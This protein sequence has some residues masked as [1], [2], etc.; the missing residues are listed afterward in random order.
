MADS[1][2][3]RRRSWRDMTQTVFGAGGGGGSQKWRSEAKPKPR[4][5][6]RKEAMTWAQK[7][8]ATAVALALIALAAVLIWWH[9]KTTPVVAV[10]VT[11]YPDPIPPNAWALEDGAALE[12]VSGSDYLRSIFEASISNG[13][14][15]A[16]EGLAALETGTDPKKWLTALRAAM[17]QGASVAGEKVVVVYLSMHGALDDQRR[18]CLIL[19]SKPQATYAELLNT[20]NWIPLRE[21]LDAAESEAKAAG[22]QIVLALDADRIDSAVEL[23]IVTNDFAKAAFGEV[24]NG[25]TQHPHVVVINSTGAGQTA[26][27]SPEMRR[28]VFSF[29]FEHGLRGAAD[30][31][32]NDD[33][34]VSVK[35]LHAYVARHVGEFVRAQFG[36]SVRQSPELWPKNATD[37]PLAKCDTDHEVVIPK[38]TQLAR[39]KTMGSLL[40]R[41]A[42]DL[43]AKGE[44]TPWRTQPEKWERYRSQLLRLER[45]LAAGDAYSSEAAAL[46]IGLNKVSFAAPPAVPELNGAAVSLALANR[47]TPAFLAKYTPADRQAFAEQVAQFAAGPVAPVTPAAAPAEGEAGAEKPAETS[48][49]G[50][51]AEAKPAEEAAPKPEAAAG[52]VKKLADQV[53]LAVR[54]HFVW[55]WFTAVPRGRD[56]FDRVM[57]AL[58]PTTSSAETPIAELQWMRILRRDFAD[59]EWAARAELIRDLAQL[60]DASEEL[61]ALV[62]ASDANNPR[63][64]DLRVL[65]PLSARIA[66]LEVRRRACEDQTFLNQFDAAQSQ[67]AQLKAEYQAVAGLARDLDGALEELDFMVAETPKLIAWKTLAQRDDAAPTWNAAKTQRVLQSLEA[68]TV[69]LE[70]PWEQG[71]PKQFD[72]LAATDYVKKT[73]NAARAERRTLENEYL[74]DVERVK[75]AATVN[76]IAEH[77]YRLTALLAVAPL[78]GGDRA[79]LLARH[80]EL[81]MELYPDRAKAAATTGDGTGSAWDTASLEEVAAWSASARRNELSGESLRRM[82]AARQVAQRKALAE[83]WKADSNRQRGAALVTLANASRR[84]TATFAPYPIA[85]SEPAEHLAWNNLSTFVGWQANRL[86]DDFLGDAD[87]V[88][89]RVQDAG[90]SRTA[91][92]NFFDLA[93]TPCIAAEKALADARLVKGDADSL[94]IVTALGADAERSAATLKHAQ[95]AAAMG[96]APS[97]GQLAAGLF[98]TLSAKVNFAN[99]AELPAGMAAVWIPS[100]PG[101]LTTGSNPTQRAERKVGPSDSA[102]PLEF[103]FDT[104]QANLQSVVLRPNA[105]FRG[106]YWRSTWSTSAAGAARTVVYQPAEKVKPQVFVADPRSDKVAFSVILD[107]SNSMTP[108]VGP[109]MMEPAKAALLAALEPVA[110]EGKHLL[111][112][113]L[114]AHR[115][116]YT[117]TG[118]RASLKLSGYFENEET[119]RLE[120]GQAPAPLKHPN[121]DIEVIRPMNREPFR[122]AD[123]NR[124]AERLDPVEACGCTPLYLSIAQTLNEDKVPP[125]YRHHIIVITDGTNQVNQAGIRFENYP[126]VADDLRQPTIA[127]LIELFRTKGRGVKLDILAILDRNDP[128]ADGVRKQGIREVLQ[129]DEATDG[130]SMFDP[131]GT[132]LIGNLRRAIGL[133][134]FRLVDGGRDISEVRQ[135]GNWVS[136]NDDV[137]IP[138]PAVVAEVLETKAKSE[139][140]PLLRSEWIKLHVEG[141]S[142]GDRLVHERYDEDVDSEDQNDRFYAAAH[143]PTLTKLQGVE[144]ELTFPVSLQ[145]ADP[146][147]YL[148]PPAEAWAEI[149]LPTR[150]GGT[151]TYWAYDLK[152]EPKKPVSVLDWT[153]HGY[154]PQ[155]GDQARVRVWWSDEPLEELA[156]LRVADL[157]PSDGVSP[158]KAPGLTLKATLEGNTLTIEERHDG[159]GTA[160]PWVRVELIDRDKIKSITRKFYPDV[161]G[162]SHRFELVSDGAQTLQNLRVRV[163]KLDFNPISN[164]SSGVQFAAFPNVRVPYYGEPSQ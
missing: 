72:V 126:D 101:L 125:G 36:G 154:E 46:A 137:A 107:C 95:A 99:A 123:W 100:V 121:E 93:A 11:E 124:L 110:R 65:A 127:Q 92:G 103:Q 23:G 85:V 25:A 161:R 136:L 58:F 31:E 140:F 8:G 28:S 152:L 135:L 109:D 87:P 7:G 106:H 71:D 82:L 97:D 26:W 138:Q 122:I 157:L 20:A 59:A 2:T 112:V 102:A 44:Q 62:D 105:Y 57:A 132:S 15:V 21:V 29:Y 149:T 128:N 90:D 104:A 163:S 108:E 120:N 119:R 114:F 32:G 49:S 98:G 5:M 117:A 83:S 64:L 115:F 52:E 19:A 145:A 146:V 86:C 63:A 14:R 134:D 55:E 144:D 30:S 47:F 16:P 141:E 67:A 9:P 6:R 18:P 70:T 162:A 17:K 77:Y 84:L 22:V 158:P 69:A 160:A 78:R 45:L 48:A 66:D 74:D 27:A 131:Q 10:C 130:M 118:N 33:S 35:E 156:E 12:S 116:T 151:I 4:T 129:L 88:F 81:A 1:N 39:T 76:T 143:K 113:R 3:P 94:D 133:Q 111:S 38:P 153:L 13:K 147:K 96:L 34:F 80:D 159:D 60:R 42:D 24:E 54:A 53:D 148:P 150:D 73:L 75:K 142:G 50:E 37:F 40:T 61:T 89:A 139:A 51:S 79:A 155:R 68:L 91:K 56:E 41:L 164:D 43:D